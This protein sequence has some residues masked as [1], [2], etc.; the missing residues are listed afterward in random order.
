MSSA[1]LLGRK[2]ELSAVERLFSDVSRTH[3]PGILMFE[4]EA[5]IGKT[6][7]WLG[8]LRRARELG[9]R[10]LFCRPSPTEAPLAFS[11]LGDV[12]GELT[13][14]FLRQLPPPQRNALEISLL[15]REAEGVVPDQRAVSL[16]AL[17]LLR[18]AS[19][20]T[21][22][23][24]AIDDV[25]WLDASSARVLAFVF[26]RIEHDRCRVLLVRRIEDGAATELP[27]DLDFAPR[28]LETLER[29]TIGPLSLGAIQSLIR[30]RL[31]ARLP[32]Q[33]LVSIC[34]ASGGNPFYAL[35]LARAQIEGG[36]LEP[37]E[38]LQV[39]A[40]LGALV[41]SRLSALP[42]STR[43]VLLIS[44][45]L[46]NP[47]V[48]VLG[49]SD[50]NSLKEAVAAGIVEIGNGQ[51]R[52]T[53]PL[54][55]SIVY[56]EASTEERRAAHAR[57]AGL[58]KSREERAR[59][60][61]LA[62]TEPDEE[63]AREL[64]L[65]AEAAAARAAPDAA[66]ELSELAAKLTPRENHNSLTRRQLATAQHLLATGEAERSRILLEALITDLGPCPERADAL[67]LLSE[68]IVD[69]DEAVLLCRQA[70]EEAAGDD[71]R[72]ARASILLSA[73]S[74]RENRNREQLEAARIA[75]EHAERCGDK[76][77]L[78]EA[79]QGVANA[80]VLLGDPID[81]PA[82]RRA[83]ELE[84]EIGGLPG[85]RSPRLWKGMQ[86]L[87]MDEIEAARPILQ[88]ETERAL[89]EGQLTEWLN[90]VPMLI[91]LE[92]RAGNWELAER[93]A[94]EAL[95]EA[96]DVG[97]SYVAQNLEVILLVIHSLR[98]ETAAREG[99]MNAVEEATRS[100]HIQAAFTSLVYLAMFETA[101]GDAGAVWRWISVIAAYREPPAG[102]GGEKGVA[103]SPNQPR[104]ILDRV[105][106][107]EALIALGDSEQ[108]N[109]YYKDLAQI[110]E[111]TRQPLA[112]ATAA[113]SRALI[114]ASRGNFD[115]AVEAFEEAL[116]T[117]AGSENPFELARTELLYGTTLRRTKRRG[118]AREMITRALERFETLGAAQWAVNARAELE[119]TGTVRRAKGDDLT[120]TERRV[121]ELVATGQSNKDVAAALFMS[122]RTVE[123]NLSKIYR[124]FGIESR[125]ELASRL[126]AGEVENPEKA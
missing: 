17:N 63:V 55:A 121:A 20:E 103:R 36:T 84:R 104:F 115:A 93:M 48:A 98:G 68:I 29:C 1:E 28:F 34:E 66:A 74:G 114:E 19:E 44:A 99:L 15:L 6:S 106:A 51:V 77:L 108:A 54:R 58:T 25:Q 14:E 76:R 96:R 69:L 12:L 32:R 113:R 91:N 86:L 94:E 27:L 16:A 56:A 90:L 123:A 33:T 13:E 43:K 38:P 124:K 78:I 22:L 112:L 97:I 37:G 60:L 88:K 45:T 64:E 122:V 57:A 50:A 83:L 7:L 80:G 24:I 92:L 52:F 116:A 79:L 59:H 89:V 49:R 9:F 23:L 42:D 40:S 81:E 5:G 109:R 102:S 35:E 62:N 87:W 30:G 47:T 95:P 119:R 72:V 100:A 10:V 71:A 105:L 4:G 2:D 101:K 31:S 18:T 8:G 82:M 107:V 117:H 118:E 3:G 11:A 61:A 125:A 26:R 41:H 65:A 85:R 75:L 111:H 126:R 46:A 70:V 39:P 110:A 67:I 21:P 73:A 120:P 53:N